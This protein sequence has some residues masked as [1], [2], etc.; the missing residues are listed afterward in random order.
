MGGP[1]RALYFSR[2]TMTPTSATKA[3]SCPPCR[4]STAMAASST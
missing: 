3:R 2:W 4:R 1:R